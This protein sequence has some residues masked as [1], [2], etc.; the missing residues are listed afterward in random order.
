LTACVCLCRSYLLIFSQRKHTA[1]LSQLPKSTTTH[2]FSLSKN[3]TTTTMKTPCLLLL[4][5]ELS[6][7]FHVQPRLAMKK[8][9]CATKGDRDMSFRTSGNFRNDVDMDRAKDCAE[10]FGKCSVKEMQQLKHGKDTIT[11]TCGINF[12]Q[13]IVL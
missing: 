10:H 5:F 2:L 9:L 4:V 3:T 7:S 1:Y 11:H 12:F 8:P 13:V 6:S